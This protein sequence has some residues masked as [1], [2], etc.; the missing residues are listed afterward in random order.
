MPILY[1]N[2][3]MVTITLTPGIV[4]QIRPIRNRLAESIVSDMA[5]LNMRD[6]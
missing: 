1:R 5:A 4:F 2:T 6:I 3:K